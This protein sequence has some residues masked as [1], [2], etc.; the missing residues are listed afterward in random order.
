MYEYISRITHLNVASLFQDLVHCWVNVTS[1]SVSRASNGPARW[2]RTGR[3]AVSNTKSS[4]CCTAFNTDKNKYMHFIVFI[5]LLVVFTVTANERF[6]SE[7]EPSRSNIWKIVQR[8]Y[9]FG[10]LSLARNCYDVLIEMRHETWFLKYVNRYLFALNYWTHFLEFFWFGLKSN[11]NIQYVTWRPNSWYDI[12]RNVA[13]NEK[14]SRKFVVGI[15]TD[16][17]YIYTYISFE[18]VLFMR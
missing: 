3:R 11:K 1:V 17:I 12:L 15:E 7:I 16:Y 8:T 18:N 2:V 9:T 4:D 5:Q 13:W 6:V 10:Y 14:G